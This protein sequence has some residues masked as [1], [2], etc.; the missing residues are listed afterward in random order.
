MDNL[1]LFIHHTER[2]LSRKVEVLLQWHG[3]GP[4]YTVSPTYFACLVYFLDIE[5]EDHRLGVF[6]LARLLGIERR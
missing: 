6:G 2:D 5:Q 3:I 1:K 4:Y